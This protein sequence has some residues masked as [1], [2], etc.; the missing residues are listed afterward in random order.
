MDFSVVVP[1]HNEA[2]NVARLFTELRSC[3]EGRFEFEVVAV[4]D[5]SEDATLERLLEARRG[6]PRVRVLRHSGRSGQ[7]AALRTGVRAARAEW[8]VTM[9]GDG[10]NDPRDIPSLLARREEAALVC[11]CRAGREDPWPKRVSSRVA[12]AV[13]AW[14]LEDG[15]P[16]TGCGL[17]VFHRETFLRLPPFDHMHRFLPAL[18]LREGATVL[19]VEVSHRPRTHGRSH[20]GILDRLGV[21]LVD[22]FGVWWL[23]RRPISASAS[24]IED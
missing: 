7:T 14:A 17:K 5:G 21:G 10:Q 23:R 4:D 12:N 19:S 8:I 18:F 20:Y 2:E 1:F 6:W 24:E 11:G 13:R 3:L 9:D 22:L 16:D 15:T